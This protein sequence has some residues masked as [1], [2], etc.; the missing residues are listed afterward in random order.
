MS[1]TPPRGGRASGGRGGSDARGR[2][3]G[4]SSRDQRS[5]NRANQHQAEGGEQRQT[6]AT[7]TGR[8]GGLETSVGTLRTDVA[9]ILAL[10]D[11]LRRSRGLAILFITHDFGVV[12]QLCDRVAV[13]YGGR[14][15]ESGPTAALLAALVRRSS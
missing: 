1:N 7:L 8:V 12:A 6:V 5:A 9:Q 2:G 3:R 10:L 13:M 4:P 14:I 11:D 15:V